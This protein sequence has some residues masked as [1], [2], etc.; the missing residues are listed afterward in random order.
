MSLFKC[1][2]LETLN[3]TKIAQR[4]SVKSSASQIV[5]SIAVQFFLVLESQGSFALAV[6]L[7]F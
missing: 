5:G 3:K 2:T 4:Q 6:L 7:T 1:R